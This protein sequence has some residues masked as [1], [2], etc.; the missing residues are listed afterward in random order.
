MT[1]PPTAP[2][3]QTPSPPQPDRT[4]PGENG[5]QLERTILSWQ[6]TALAFLGCGLVVTHGIISGRFQVVEIVLGITLALAGTAICAMQIGRRRA[7]DPI[8][9]ARPMHFALIAGLVT[10]AAVASWWMS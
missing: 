7:A 5:L 8:T 6:R 2:T 4:R 3:A 9:P 1:E 10:A